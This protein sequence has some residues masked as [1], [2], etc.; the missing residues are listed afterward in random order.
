[1]Q[2]Y[3]VGIFFILIF[4]YYLLY[5]INLLERQKIKANDEIPRSSAHISIKDLSPVG[6]LRLLLISGVLDSPNTAGIG[7]IGLSSDSTTSSESGV[8]LD[9]P[10]TVGVGPGLG[11]GVGLGVGAGPGLE[12]VEGTGLGLVGV[13]GTGLGLV[14]VVGVGPG[15]V[16][17]GFGSGLGSGLGSG[18]GGVTSFVLVTIK[19]LFVSPEMEDV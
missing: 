6:V 12:G 8:G 18:F 13:E 16:G 1:M 11:V 10:A 9:S 2:T 4:I 3:I 7:G 17:S 15:G 19:P 5:F 14:G